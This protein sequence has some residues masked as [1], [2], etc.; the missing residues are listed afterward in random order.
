MK[1]YVSDGDRYLRGNFRWVKISKQRDGKYAVARGWDG[2]FK[3]KVGGITRNVRR[4]LDAR[5]YA[6]SWINDG[7]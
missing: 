3:A 5:S 1:W 4:L 7:H 6:E 2:D